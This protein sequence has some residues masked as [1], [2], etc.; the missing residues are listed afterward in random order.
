MK[1]H[2]LHFFLRCSLLRSGSKVFLLSENNPLN[3]ISAGGR[4][5]FSIFKGFLHFQKMVTLWANPKRWKETI[6]S[7]VVGSLPPS[8]NEPNGLA[9]KEHLGTLND[10]TGPNA[11]RKCLSSPHFPPKEPLEVHNQIFFSFLQDCLKKSFTTCN[12]DRKQWSDLAADRVAWRH[13]IHQAAAHFE[14]DR[15]NSLKDKR[16]R[17]KA[18]AASTITPGITFPCSHCSRPCLPHRPG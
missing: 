4:C 16:Q 6:S 10:I 18:R 1:S 9:A 17:R 15:R 7:C 12:I 8:A 11:P 14:V 2:T 5:N 13:T 3:D